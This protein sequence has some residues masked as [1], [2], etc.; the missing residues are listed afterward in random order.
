MRRKLKLSLGLFAALTVALSCQTNDIDDSFASG[1][2]SNAVS[3][4][5]GE[6]ATRATDTAFEAG[7]V[8]SVTAYTSDGSTF[9]AN[10]EYTFNG[11]TF[12][13][14]NPITYEDYTQKLSFRAAYPA[15]EIASD[16]TI[17]FEAAQD[18]SS[19][20][21]LSD[22]M[23]S[24]IAETSE[25]SPSLTFSHVMTK[26]VVSVTSSDVDMNN[27]TA[28]LGA[29]AGVVCDLEAASTE[30]TGESTEITM[31]SNGV[32][33]FKAV[34]APQTIASGAVLG[35]IT[36][37]GTPYEIS[38]NSD[39]TLESG[40]SYSVEAKI[41]GGKI[42]VAWD[43]YDAADYPHD[44]LYARYPMADYTTEYVTPHRSTPYYNITM[45][46]GDDAS[47]GDFD[48]VRVLEYMPE[49][50]PN[51]SLEA[52]QE[53][54][55]K[56][57]SDLNHYFGATGRFRTTQD[58]NGRWWIVDPEGYA[59]IQRGL[60]TVRPVNGLT[61]V[62][63]SIW[64]GSNIAWI[65]QTQAEFYDMGMH[66]SGAFTSDGYYEY[67]QSYN[68]M[69][70][71]SPLTIAPSYSFISAFMK[72]YGYDYPTCSGNYSGGNE[73][74][75]LTLAHYP[76]WE[77]FCIYYADVL[78]G[79]FFGDPNFFGFF[80]DNELQF[81]SAN[82]FLL[83]EVWYETDATNPAKAAAIKV[84][85]ELGY[86][87]AEIDAEIA[88][89]GRGIVQEGEL[90]DA[91]VYATA[92]KYYSGIS[93]GAKYHDPEI[94]YLGSRLHGTPKYVRPAVMAAG[95]AC[96]VISINYYTAW[97]PQFVN[98][99]QELYNMGYNF[100][101]YRDHSEGY[102][103]VSMWEEANAP[104]MISEFYVKGSEYEFSN[105][106]GAGESVADELDRALWYQHFT[107][108][109]LESPSCV[110]WH[111]FRYMD[112]SDTNRGFY[113]QSFVKYPL[114]EKYASELN[115]NTYDI[116]DY[117]DSKNN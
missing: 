87:E 111:W 26:V 102:G 45:G 83:D 14:E 80:S 11:S 110:G 38:F 86:T 75:E 53:R 74:A 78:L 19:D 95:E 112:D 62:W 51:Y 6:I 22:L 48:D 71:D 4:T 50:T 58:E 92:L 17:S 108:G 7:D 9:A 84:V 32:N 12:T 42:T 16:K 59:H 99:G 5:V 116:I 39:L 47:L 81:T 10:V 3:F 115:Y 1:G 61:G 73:Y 18:Q 107:L 103:G 93:A 49:F 79:G 85:E 101:S 65:M 13:S 113:T 34:V 63:E 30:A 76:Y 56:Y 35:T 97:A 54:T 20:Y 117:F 105:S 114:M 94:L 88:A 89:N 57:G 98:S 29:V 24:S 33:S 64:G 41:A 44:E 77:E 46:H 27:A 91:Y 55:N 31:A 109:L 104:F 82:Y 72:E 100:S 66:A 23:V 68:N 40:C 37:N 106:D 70:P 21:T 96:D 43:D 8:I 15:T 69:F 52:Y 67:I 36:A 25:K 60:N 28:S 90:N 2:Y